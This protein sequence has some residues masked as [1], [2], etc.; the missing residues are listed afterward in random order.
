M[1]QKRGPL[2]AETLAKRKATIAKN[3]AAKLKTARVEQRRAAKLQQPE[4]IK[5]PKME[6]RAINLRIEQLESELGMLKRS[7]TEV[8]ANTQQIGAS[9][10]EFREKWLPVI[11][12]SLPN[13]RPRV[14]SNF[15]PNE[16]PYMEMGAPQVKV[17]DQ[18]PAGWEVAELLRRSPQWAEVWPGAYPNSQARQVAEM[19]EQHVRNA[20]ALMLR[21]MR[22]EMGGARVRS[23][24]ER[25]R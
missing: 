18:P 4:A 23:I 7:V 1:P 11:M 16:Y 17:N 25:R 14:H 21:A 6:R 2:S 9:W 5:V 15:A 24:L 10:D 3:K 22:R 20:L 13:A 12:K 8:G 19:S